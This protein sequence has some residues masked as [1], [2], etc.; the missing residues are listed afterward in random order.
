M[1]I[2]RQTYMLADRPIFRPIQ[3]VGNELQSTKL[4]RACAQ[5]CGMVRP[6]MLKRA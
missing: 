4:A 2:F 6:D 5:Y 1:V 3:Y